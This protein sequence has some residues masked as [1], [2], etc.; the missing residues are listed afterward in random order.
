[1]KRAACICLSAVIGALA[2]AKDVEQIAIV[3]HEITT[4]TVPFGI[5]SYAPSN[6]DVARI[7]R[8]SDTSLRITA[9]R[10]GRCDLEVRGDRNLSQKYEINVLG[11]LA[12]V[13]EALTQEL[14]SVPEV[15]AH[16]LGES[17][18][19]DGE[20]GSIRKWE[21]LTKVLKNYAG[22]IRNF[23]VFQPGP[24]VVKNLGATLEQAGFKVV[25]A[26]LGKDRAKWVYDTVALVYDRRTRIISVQS[27]VFTDEAKGRILACLSSE[28][29]LTVQLNTRADEKNPD[30]EFLVR[31][32]VDVEVD[33]PTIRLSTAYLVVG[34]S[35][36][37]SAGSSDLPMVKG[38][39]STLQ[40]L[41]H[42]GNT[43]TAT[44]GADLNTTIGFLAKNGISRV[45]Q[46]AYTAF[47]SWDP[48]GTQFKS[49]GKLN[50]RVAG[51]NNG[52]L[53]EVPY[54][55]DVTV[56]GGLVSAE[57][58]KLDLDIS[59]S[60]V[61]ILGNGDVDQKEEKSKQKLVCKLGKT[62][63]IGGFRQLVDENTPPSGLPILRNTPLLSWFVAESGQQISD[64][65]LLILVCPEIHDGTRD[66]ALNVDA[67]ITLP[68]LDDASKTT[69][70][71]LEE[72]KKYH[73]FLYWMNWFTF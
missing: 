26:Q 3:E 14:E 5:K 40:N 67:E 25:N 46:K 10:R 63:V 12:A 41:I 69:E 58:A 20:I 38:V 53:K 4:I 23:V 57:A 59:I 68:T 42:G 32:I 60:G 6:K 33:A 52:D 9:Q 51:T 54:G 7:E 30:A 2:F 27:K 22:S 15:R 11:D 36:I 44:I 16:V 48:S 56:K 28:R 37:R 49:G 73:G 19:L 61:T 64:R 34:D 29:W 39:F 65:R 70:E 66:E 62:T 35:D 47:Q 21:Y 17:I 55:F 1:M 45:S 50:V 72:R 13:F 8:L 18:R 31:A 24:E 71:R 43:H